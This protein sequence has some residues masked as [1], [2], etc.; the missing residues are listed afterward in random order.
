[1]AL[2]S[3]RTYVPLG[4][5]WNLRSHEGHGRGVGIRGSEHPPSAGRRVKQKAASGA[6]R[7]SAHPARAQCHA[8]CAP[9]CAL[10][11]QRAE[12]RH[13][14]ACCLPAQRAQQVLTA[15]AHTR[16]PTP[17]PA[18]PPR[19]AATAGAR[20]GAAR[21]RVNATTGESQEK[22]RVNPQRRVVKLPRAEESDPAKRESSS[23]RCRLGHFIGP[24]SP[25]SKGPGFPAQMFLAG[26]VRP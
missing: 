16:H 3:Y 22:E 4:S 14:P 24:Q 23:C 21:R 8:C 11:G 10:C 17:P 1:M 15:P 20:S 18:A 26:R 6:G 13:S 2:A 12:L 19:M 25:T 9:P 5:V 7:S